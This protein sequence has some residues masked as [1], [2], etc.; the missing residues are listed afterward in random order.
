V[1]HEVHKIPLSTFQIASWKQTKAEQQ[2]NI[3]GRCVCA[4]LPGVCVCVCLCT[5]QV[6]QCT[7]PSG[8]PVGSRDDVLG[9]IGL[10]LPG[11]Q[12]R[13]CL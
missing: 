8:Q 2:E 5:S 1:A 10:R 12:V 7:D 3:G 4:A 6:Q 13:L 9:V 11:L